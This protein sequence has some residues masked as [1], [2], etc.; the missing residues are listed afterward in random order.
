MSKGRKQ[1]KEEKNAPEADRVLC[2]VT[3]RNATGGDNEGYE[4]QAED[5]DDLGKGEPELGL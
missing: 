1:G 2:R 5:G 3:S 4:D